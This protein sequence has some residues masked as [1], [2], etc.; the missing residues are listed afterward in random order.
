MSQ[1]HPL[2]AGLAFGRIAAQVLVA[3]LPRALAF[4]TGVLGFANVFQNG[5]PVAFVILEK[6]GAELHL[7]LEPQHR[8]GAHNVAHL[9]VNDAAALHDHLV[10]HGATIVKALRD[11]DYRMRTFVFADPD[12]NRIDVGQDL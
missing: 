8:G 4:Y 7:Q 2:P 1:P 10:A 3:D 9:M 6:Q 11:A 12:G 5:D